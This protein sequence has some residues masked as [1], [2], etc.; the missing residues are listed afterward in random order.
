MT[1]PADAEFERVDH[2]SRDWA[3][4]SVRILRRMRETCPVARS[5]E[6]G[7]Y[8]VVSTYDEVRRL[9][10]DEKV[11]S[12]ARVPGTPLR[13]SNIPGSA[14]AA[15]MGMA[16]MTQDRHIAMR[17]A[18]NPWFDRARLDELMSG[19]VADCHAAIDGFIETGRCDL[20][21]DLT[22]IVPAGLTMRMLG[23]PTELTKRFASAMHRGVAVPHGSPDRPAVNQEVAWV[24]EYIREAVRQRRESPR[25]D[26]ASD[27]ANIVIDGE[28]I[29]V[30][31]AVGQVLLLV[32]GGMDTTSAL[33]SQALYWLSRH[34]AER[35][36]LREDLNRL[37]AAAEEFI[38]Y[39]SPVQA[40]ARTATEDCVVAGREIPQWSR[41]LLS[42]A[43]ANRDA[44]QFPEPDEVR[45][46][47]FPN[48]HL[49]FAAGSR[50]CLGA[51]M[52]RAMF[53]VV[54]GAVLERLP[55]YRIDPADVEQYESIGII[56]GL[57]SLPAMFAPGA[58]RAPTGNP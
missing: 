57:K 45:L 50:Y 41:L 16:D 28:R 20:I 49:G 15:N 52:A 54:V 24:G 33:M 9:A 43:S 11:F 3:E 39:F 48:R 58:R 21:D 2:N 37:D 42:F 38:R 17:R 55:H 23:F 25:D 40:L 22:S 44:A 30:E 27:M 29:S 32:S 10:R 4:D 46:D 36:W 7:G 51:D 12:T 6:H 13:G 34:P 14:L 5:R 19:I 31:D 8:Y 1:Q 26:M 18:T 53:K 35:E 56:N 47:R